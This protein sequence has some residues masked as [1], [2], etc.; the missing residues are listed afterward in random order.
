MNAVS[1]INGIEM[2]STPSVYHALNAPIHGCCST[3]CIAAVAGSNSRQSSALRTKVATD[4][5]SASHRPMAAL[6]SPTS[7]SSTPAAIG[8]QTSTLRMGQSTLHVVVSAC[9]SRSHA[10]RTERP[11]IVAKA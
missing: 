2:P 3:N 7:S 6:R 11:M 1:T 4:A 8:S 5:T 9:A 10:S